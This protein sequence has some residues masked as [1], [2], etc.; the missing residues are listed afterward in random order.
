MKTSITAL[1]ALL[2]KPVRLWVSVR[3][4]R[5]VLYQRMQDGHPDTA[6]SAS[7]QQKKEMEGDEPNNAVSCCSLL[8]SDLSQR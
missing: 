7:A 6:T 2:L 1:V 8:S 3:L 5:L 4:A